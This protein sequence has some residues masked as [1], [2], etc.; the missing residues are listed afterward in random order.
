MGA[1]LSS[2]LPS[3]MQDVMINWWGSHNLFGLWLTPM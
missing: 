1:Q 2:A 3:P